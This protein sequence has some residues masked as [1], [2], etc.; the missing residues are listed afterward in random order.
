[1]KAK[2][3]GVLLGLLAV[4]GFYSYSFA[5]V[6]WAA[7]GA[8]KVGDPIL[9]FVVSPDGRHFFVLTKGGN[10][11]IYE[12]DGKSVGT[13][14]TG[15]AADHIAL[16]ADGGQIFLSDNESGTIEW[17]DFDFVVDI[18]LSG[19]PYEGPKDAPVVLAV[20]GDFQ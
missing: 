17:L 3:I 7:S 18:N 12:R 19:S 13:I 2:H 14:A 15:K 20:F 10:I 16:S 4:I 1:M 6:E 8:L 11:S 9:D 5:R